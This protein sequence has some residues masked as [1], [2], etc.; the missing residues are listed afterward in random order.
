[1]HVHMLV[2]NPWTPIAKGVILAGDLK[3]DVSL[4][5][6]KMLPHDRSSLCP[7]QLNPAYGSTLG[8]HVRSLNA[9]TS[10]VPGGPSNTG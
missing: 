7:K 6:A 1:M 8:V 9:S 5:C 2:V 10:N 4:Y 3:T